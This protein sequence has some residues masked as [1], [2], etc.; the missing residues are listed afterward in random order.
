MAG[1][2]ESA[3]RQLKLLD[4]QAKQNIAEYYLKE[5]LAS[6][7]AEKH[8]PWNYSLGRFENIRIPLR[9]QTGLELPPSLVR[10]L[11]LEKLNWQI[12]GVNPVSIILI[13]G[14]FPQPSNDTANGTEKASLNEALAVIDIT[15]QGNP[16]LPYE[17]WKPF[18]L[19]VAGVLD[20]ELGGKRVI[21]TTYALSE[22]GNR[23][24]RLNVSISSR[25]TFA[26]A[27]TGKV[28]GLKA[29]PTN[30]DH[31]Y[32]TAGLITQ[33]MQENLEIGEDLLQHGSAVVFELEN[34][35]IIDEQGCWGLNYTRKTE[36][37]SI[38]VGLPEDEAKKHGLAPWEIILPESL[39]KA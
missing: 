30:K 26:N 21:A 10:G 7:D 37:G 12:L 31:P 6:A 29:I 18:H 38:T 36:N 19:R 14:N 35:K 33:A 1:I 8:N 17:E 16:N 25:E 23:L 9:Q 4:D 28:S 5:A 39:S 11:N 3:P 15:R 13:G 24:T 27:H 20:G 34:Q 32:R 22:T 2:S